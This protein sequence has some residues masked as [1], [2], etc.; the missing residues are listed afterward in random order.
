M[1]RFRLG[2][3]KLPFIAEIMVPP[4]DAPQELPI[5]SLPQAPTDPCPIPEECLAILQ[6]LDEET[7]EKCCKAM[8]NGISGEPTST[9]KGVLRRIANT[10]QVDDVIALSWSPTYKLYFP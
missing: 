4:V 10:I 7:L 8:R 3:A 9:Q 1:P 6:S 2:S 5:P